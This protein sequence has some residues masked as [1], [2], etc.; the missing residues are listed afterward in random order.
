LVLDAVRKQPRHGYE[1]IQAIGEKTRGAYR[2]SPGVVYPTLQMLEELGHIRAVTRDDR[3]VYEITEGG[4]R[5]LDDHGDDVIDFYDRFEDRMWDL[6][7]DEVAH[8]MGRIG[9]VIKAFKRGARRGRFRPALVREML[10]VLDDAMDK[11]QA[12]LAEDD[13]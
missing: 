3:K 13:E 7:P 9:Q 12:L 2:P 6:R 11:L 8:V 1:I 4:K 5:D 10:V